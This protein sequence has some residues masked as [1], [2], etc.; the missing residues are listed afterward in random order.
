MLPQVGSNQVTGPSVPERKKVILK[1][2]D[3]SLESN[4]ERNRKRYCSV[5]KCLCSVFP[6]CCLFA[7]ML[8]KGTGGCDVATSQACLS[9]PQRERGWEGEREE[10][11]E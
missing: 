2:K 11:E 10:E 5:Q 4:G 7:N 6:R 9:K 8:N 3:S 1:G